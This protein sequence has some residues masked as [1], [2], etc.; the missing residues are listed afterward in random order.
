MRDSLYGGFRKLGDPNIVGK[1]PLERKSCV[2]AYCLRVLPIVSI[3]VPFS[4]LTKYI[5]RIL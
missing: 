3:V 5:I 4:G 1:D 2:S